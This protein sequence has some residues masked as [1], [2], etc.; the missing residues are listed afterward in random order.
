MSASTDFT[1]DLSDSTPPKTYPPVAPGTSYPPV[2][3][4]DYSRR[5]PPVLPAERISHGRVKVL[6]RYCSAAR[7]KATYHIHG[8]PVEDD[9]TRH[10]VAPCLSA[11]GIETPYSFV[12]YVLLVV[13]SGFNS[14]ESLRRLGLKR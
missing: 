13:E 12:G 1:I 2:E 4:P 5:R 3:P 14:P 8:A 7:K 9:E 10:R 11:Y 6:C